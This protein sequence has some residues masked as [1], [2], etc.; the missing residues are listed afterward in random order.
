MRI[1]LAGLVALINAF[2]LIGCGDS[3]TLEPHGGTG[4]ICYTDGSCD[5]DLTCCDGICQASCGTDGDQEA[6]G[7][8]VPDGDQA[9]DGDTEELPVDGD[10]E[11]LP[12]DGDVEELP[13]DGDVEELPVDGDVEETPVDGDL[14]DGDMIEFDF[15]LEV[16]GDLSCIDDD[17]PGASLCNASDECEV[18]CFDDES[19]N[20]DCPDAYGF[21]TEKYGDC[22][23][24][25]CDDDDDCLDLGNCDDP[26]NS[27][28]KEF[29]CD[30]NNQCKRDI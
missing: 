12:A 10:A 13:V 8:E 1:L 15:E 5:A 27:S 28:H 4:E 9:A 24:V 23:P 30:T 26:D 19:Y 18:L 16:D 25:P 20:E 22:E 17:C 29:I 2:V 14:V 11:E 21:M 7:D 3:W 6:D